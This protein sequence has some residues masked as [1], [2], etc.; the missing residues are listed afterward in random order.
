MSRQLPT[1]SLHVLVALLGGEKHGYAIKRDVEHLSDGAVRM[2]PGTLYGTVGRLVGDGLMEEVDG[3]ADSEP[4]AERR[5]YYRLTHDGTS[6]AN[7]ELH[8]LQT[9]LQRVGYLRPGVGGAG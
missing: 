6:V 5:R 7:D 3:P 4:H 2:G 9:L 8:R 1:A